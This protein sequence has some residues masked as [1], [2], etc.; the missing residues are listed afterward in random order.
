MASFFLYLH[1]PK[2]LAQWLVSEHYSQEKGAIV[3]PR[4]SNERNILEL[5]L[6]K[7]PKDSPPSAPRPDD[8]T[9]E[10]PSFAYKP[11]ST[12]N[13]LPSRGRDALVSAIKIRFKKMMWE[14]LH[15][16]RPEEVKITD[17]I[18]AFLEKHGIEGDQQN[19]ETVRQMY[20][21]MRKVYRKS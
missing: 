4:G 2:Y 11:P 10:I 18:Y 16:I 6:T 1:L 7:R 21:R 17:L 9:V 12:Y 3:F 14:E 8:I 19:W 15:Q 5:F 20:F 13:H